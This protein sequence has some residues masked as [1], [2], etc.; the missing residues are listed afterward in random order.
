MLP[1]PCF[2]N[3]AEKLKAAAVAFDFYYPNHYPYFHRRAKG[4]ESHRGGFQI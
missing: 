1:K 2:P 3:L 4:F